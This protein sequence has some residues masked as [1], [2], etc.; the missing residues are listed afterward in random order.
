[1]DTPQKPILAL[2]PLHEVTDAAFRETILACGAPDL[3]YTEFTSVDGL[4]HEIGKDRLIRRYL[5]RGETEVN[6]RAQFFGT[7]PEKFMHAARIA[8][9]L[10]FAGVDINMGCPASLVVKNSAGGG[11]IKDP[12]RALEI[13]AATIE[14]AAGLPV[15]VKTRLGYSTDIADEWI[16][17]LLG[18]GI[19][20]LTLHARTVKEMSKV[21]A[22]WNRVKDFAPL[23]R[24]RGILLIGNGDIQSRADALTRIAEAGC[25][26][27]MIGRAIFGNFWFFN[28]DIRTDDLSLAEKLGALSDFAE[29]FEARYGEFRSLS[30]L[31]KHV[32]GLV[33]GFPGSAE[34]RERLMACTTAAE[35]RKVASTYA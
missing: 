8:H 15:S 23:A 11:L 22:K 25:D 35:F 2:A 14:G 10:G 28:P 30:T 24:E 4:A 16:P 33:H 5:Q 13:I 21:P 17:A 31:R 3:M 19:D 9:Q 27:A 32:K 18:T 20:I 26:G 12:Q 1:M 34:V 7:D 6:T 29:R